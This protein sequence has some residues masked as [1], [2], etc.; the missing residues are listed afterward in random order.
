MSDFC[1]VLL[2]NFCRLAAFRPRAF[3]RCSA[4]RM[5]T[6]S[7]PSR[8]THAHAHRRTRTH[9][10]A[11]ARTHS[12]IHERAT[13]CA[14]AKSSVRSRTSVHAFACIR[15]HEPRRRSTRLAWALAR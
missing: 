8:H 12:R 1:T 10:H 7:T 14:E 4:A 15:L 6:L 2:F 5:P 9:A 13:A 11:H 3:D